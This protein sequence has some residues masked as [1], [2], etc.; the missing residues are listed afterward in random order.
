MVGMGKYGMIPNQRYKW[1]WNDKLLF[2]M[3]IIRLN[4]E[5]MLEI[6]Q[7]GQTCQNILSAVA[8]GKSWSYLDWVGS[9]CISNKVKPTLCFQMTG[10]DREYL[11]PMT[12]SAGQV[13]DWR[14][15]S[16]ISTSDSPDCELRSKK[17]G[18]LKTAWKKQIVDFRCSRGW[19]INCEAGLNKIHSLGSIQLMV[20]LQHT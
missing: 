4:D 2:W 5:N 13:R 1:A 12:R 15:H 6:S 19:H 14:M 16:E 17:S 20:G 9:I 10:T 8:T 18:R 3:L 11:R 7:S